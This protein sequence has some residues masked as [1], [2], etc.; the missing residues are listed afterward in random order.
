MTEAL[1][2]AETFPPG[3]FIRDEIRARGLTER[4]FELF[5]FSKG[6]EPIEVVACQFAAYVD[7]KNL[8]LDQK[9]ADCLGKVFDV[10][11]GYFINLDRAWRGVS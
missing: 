2:P 6:L 9:T 11:P 1:T 10:S 8:I 4:G 3:E 5:C 7:D